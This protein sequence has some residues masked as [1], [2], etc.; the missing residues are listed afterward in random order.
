MTTVLTIQT[1]QAHKAGKQ[2]IYRAGAAGGLALAGLLLLVKPR[3]R[4]LAGL[5]WWVALLMVLGLGAAIGCGGGGSSSGG[6]GGGG[7]T[8]DPGTP[9]G[10]STVTVTA[11]AGSL[12]EATKL[13]LTVQ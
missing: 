11:T 12:S 6:G 5:G 3:T 7:Q 2:N 13:Q 8:T 9:A 4:L 1:T 10:T